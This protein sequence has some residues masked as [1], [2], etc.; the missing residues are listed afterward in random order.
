MSER[1]L[2]RKAFTL[3]ELLTVV[4]I[5]TLLLSMLLPVLRKSREL[6]RRSVCGSNIK[7]LT[8]AMLIYS[9]NNAGRIPLGYQSCNNWGFRQTDYLVNYS[10]NADHWA[11]PDMHYGCLVND[12]LVPFPKQFYCP[13]EKNPLFQFNT[14]INPWLRGCYDP[15]YE[16]WTRF[17][18]GARPLAAWDSGARWVSAG[19]PDHDV[20]DLPRYQRLEP[21]TTI[22]ADIVSTLDYANLRHAEGVNFATASGSIHWTTT[23]SF[24]RAW[25]D[26][27]GYTKHSW[28]YI[29]GEGTSD[30]TGDAGFYEPGTSKGVWFDMDNASRF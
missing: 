10:P 14:A 19:W 7:A 3:V 9:T 18:Y 24:N 27:G 25:Q 16:G 28:D 23:A 5:I 12:K 26:W 4:A 30:S 2:T 1:R 6:A 11:R 8:V 29:Y 15:A 21:G 13:S 22:L 20:K 17:G